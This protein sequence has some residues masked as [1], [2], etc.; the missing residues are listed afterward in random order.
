MDCCEHGSFHHTKQHNNKNE[1][2]IMITT[3]TEKT[4]SHTPSLKGYETPKS[5]NKP[6]IIRQLVEARHRKGMTQSQVATQMGTTASAIAR[7]ESGG[8]KKRHSPSLRTLKMYAE[9]IGY[10]IA[11]TLVAL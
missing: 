11:M 3:P 7:L 8:G 2:F 4:N 10:N 9:A 6:D 5:N 1:D